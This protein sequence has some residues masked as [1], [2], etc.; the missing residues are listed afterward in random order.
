LD[1][2]CAAAL[3]KASKL[4]MDGRNALEP[5]LVLEAGLLYHRL[6]RG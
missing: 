2:G 4:L 5:D 1:V 6:G 3:M